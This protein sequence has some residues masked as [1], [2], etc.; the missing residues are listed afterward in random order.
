MGMFVGCVEMLHKHMTANL[1]MSGDSFLKSEL[2]SG[3]APLSTTAVWISL[4]A[5]R[6]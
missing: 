5:D 2:S 3:M 4:C 1:R 6:R